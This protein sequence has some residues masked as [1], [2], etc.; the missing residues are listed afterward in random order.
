[1]I[2]FVYKKYPWFKLINKKYLIS[3]HVRTQY[4]FN[5]FEI[6]GS[7]FY[8]IKLITKKGKVMIFHTV[9]I[10]VPKVMLWINEISL[11]S[12]INKRISSNFFLKNDL[13]VQ[14]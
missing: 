14:K 8:W 2:T 7:S 9:E 10:F 12:N 1:M 13:K 4:L 11:L 5:M 3:R 6:T